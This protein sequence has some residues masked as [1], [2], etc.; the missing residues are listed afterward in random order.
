MK[1]RDVEA[2]GFAAKLMLTGLEQAAGHRR[3]TAYKAAQHWNRSCGSAWIS[4]Y[5]LTAHHTPSIGSHHAA[6]Q[7]PEEEHH[8][9]PPVEN[10]PQDHR[11]SQTQLGGI[12]VAA[13]AALYTICIPMA[14]RDD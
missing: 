14:R 9:L 6:R 10:V 2:F 13:H 12:S 7:G 11:P 3:D 4:R 1:S 5:V 8:Q